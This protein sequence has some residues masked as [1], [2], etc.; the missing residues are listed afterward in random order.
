MDLQRILITSSGGVVAL[1][2]KPMNHRVDGGHL[3]VNPPRE[4]WE[5]SELNARELMQWA[6]LVAA[7][8]QAMLETLPQLAGGC[9]NYWE[10]GNYGLNELTEPVGAKNPRIHRKM[11]M[12][13]FGRSMDATHPDWRWGE[14]PRFP[15]YVDSAAWASQFTQLNFYE[16]DAI[17]AK[18]QAL[19]ASKYAEAF[20]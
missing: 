2:T 4:V 10:A 5:R 15:R 13:I 17:Q 1:P 7:T 12:H 6:C 14:A 3:L 19:L 16:C 9:I 18:I 11:H 20:T 8:A